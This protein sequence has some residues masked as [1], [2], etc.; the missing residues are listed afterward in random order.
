MQKVMLDKQTATIK[1]MVYAY[2]C[3]TREHAVKIC[4]GDEDKARRVISFLIKYGAIRTSEDEQTLKPHITKLQKVEKNTINCITVALDLVTDSENPDGIYLDGL[5]ESFSNPPV[6]ICLIS[7]DNKYY[8]ILPVSEDNSSAVLGFIRDKYRRDYKTPEAADGIEY[9][10]VIT[11]KT[12]LP[13]IGSIGVNFTHRIALV[14]QDE[15]GKSKVTY[16]NPK[17]KSA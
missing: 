8:N 6:K 17:T 13:V 16:F 14:S 9:V 2:G 5:Q 7:Q 15:E 10:F 4:N 12:M 1:A 3:L 11:D